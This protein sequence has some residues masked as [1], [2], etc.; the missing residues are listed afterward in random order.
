MVS[1]VTRGLLEYSYSTLFAFAPGLLLA[2]GVSLALYSTTTFVALVAVGS[3]FLRSLI[4]TVMPVPV[5][6]TETPSA[7]VIVLSPDFTTTEPSTIA[8][9]VGVSLM[10]MA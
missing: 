5:T 2:A 1:V 7:L 10:V 6:L 4:F 3:A 9:L 8:R